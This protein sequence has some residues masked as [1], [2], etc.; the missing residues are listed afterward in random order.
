MTTPNTVR[1]ADLIT[2]GD[3]SH[4]LRIDKATLHRWA[5]AGKVTPIMI[6]GV[7]FF[8]R[9][10]IEKIRAEREAAAS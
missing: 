5:A 3:A 4:E 2:A 6:A 10:E 9:D 1:P 8:R 7:R